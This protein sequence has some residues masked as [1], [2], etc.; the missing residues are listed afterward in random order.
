MTEQNGATGDVGDVSQDL[1]KFPL[2][3]DGSVKSLI[4]VFSFSTIQFSPEKNTWSG[5]S[6]SWLCL[7]CLP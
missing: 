7:S 2:M 4:Y 3:P 1:E 6:T 5:V